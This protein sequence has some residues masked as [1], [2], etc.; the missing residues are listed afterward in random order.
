MLN[1]FRKTVAG[2][3][4]TWGS[5]LFHAARTPGRHTRHVDSI[6]PLWNVLDLSPGGRH[7][8]WLPALAYEAL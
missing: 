7:P 3:H 1:V 2:V 8:T 5:E 6:W 4:H